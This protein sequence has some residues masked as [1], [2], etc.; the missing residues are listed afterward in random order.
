MKTF[1]TTEPVFDMIA[2]KPRDFRAWFGDKA[3]DIIDKLD[4]MPEFTLK[5][6]QPGVI[7]YRQL[8]PDMVIEYRF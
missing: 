4:T 2:L 7:V 3:K 6:K 1:R 5:D 8:L